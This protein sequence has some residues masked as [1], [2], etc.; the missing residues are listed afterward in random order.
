MQLKGTLYYYAVNM[1]YM[2]MIFW[3]IMLGILLLSLVS[4]MLFGGDKMY[5]YYSFSIPSYA[6]AASVVFLVFKYI[7]HYLLKIGITRFSIY[8]SFSI[9]MYAFA[10]A[11]GFWVV[12]NIIPYLVKMGITRL[13]IYLGTGI[14]FLFLVIFNGTNA[15]TMEFLGSNIIGSDI[16]SGVNITFGNKNISSTSALI[17]LFAKDTLW[18]R[19]V[20]DVSIQFFALAVG[21]MFGMI[22]YRYKLIGGASVFALLLFIFIYSINSGWLYDT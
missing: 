13:S 21:F 8:Y 14:M 3:G 5:I 22:F 16:N 15:N 4:D 11:V 18:N 2:L 20:I 6:F 1:R 12:K 19:F 7:I 10:A 9:P 17:E